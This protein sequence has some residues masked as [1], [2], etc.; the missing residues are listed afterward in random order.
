MRRGIA[1]RKLIQ[2]MSGGVIETGRAS[3][4]WIDFPMPPFELGWREIAQCGV[5]TASNRKPPLRAYVN[6]WRAR[7]RK[8]LRW[9]LMVMRQQ[10]EAC[11]SANCKTV[12][13]G[14]INTEGE[15]LWVPL[16]DCAG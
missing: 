4:G 12:L 7:G 15:L 6:L 1:N 16:V 8:P 11:A 9:L 5:V 14:G 10:H 3:I 13:R 2:T